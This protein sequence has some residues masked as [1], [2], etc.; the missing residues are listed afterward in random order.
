[1][2]L[3]RRCECYTSYFSGDSSRIDSG[4][5]V[6]TA[7]RL[8]LIFILAFVL[9]LSYEL[10]AQSAA[11]SIFKVVHTPNE[12]FNND[13][14]AASASSADDIWAVGQ[15]AM[16]YDGTAW[17]AFPVPHINGSTSELMGVVDISP[18]E[19]W[20]GGL[21]NIGIA[22]P[23]QIIVKWDG[24]EWSVVPGPK[25]A[26]GD[27]PAIY[28]MT[29]TSANDIWAVGDDLTD[30]GNA[31]VAIFEHWDGSQWTAM[32]GEFGTPFLNGASADATNDAWAVGYNA[33]VIDD[34]ATLAMH[35]NGETWSAVG[36]PNVGQGNNELH[37]VVALAPDNV[38]AVGLS[39]PSAQSPTL[40]LI[41][42]YDGTSWSVVSSP[43]VGPNSGYQSN[44]LFGITANSATDIWAFGSYFAADGSGHQMTL[45][46]HWD[47]T[48]WTIQPSPDPTKKPKNGSPGFLS[49]VLWAGVVPTPGNVWIVGS[50]DE[51]PQEGSLA[52]H[53]TTGN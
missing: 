31:L 41:E 42:H 28:A 47:G 18:T 17:T 44:R 3:T 34:N 51:P 45:L 1:M 13:M 40:T 43:N 24:T 19:A 27:Q 21:V 32:F 15:S 29:S 6:K 23:G 16:H 10:R 25:L 50:E 46:L 5:F 12:N 14:F 4:G 48:S 37:G 38:W 20:A 49:D 11:A 39:T 2:S 7:L 9:T 22:N 33:D 8:V 30:D 36:T 26:K 35:W 52:I 53:T